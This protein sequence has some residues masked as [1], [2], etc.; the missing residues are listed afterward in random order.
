MQIN[1]IHKLQNTILYDVT[2]NPVVERRFG[3]TYCLH[4]Q[5]RGISQGKTNNNY[6][7]WFIL[8]V[9]FDPEEAIF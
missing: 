5:W 8:K 1:I 6:T 3:V 9:F 4:F 2:C 7:H